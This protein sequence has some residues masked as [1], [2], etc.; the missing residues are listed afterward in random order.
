MDRPNLWSDRPLHPANVALASKSETLIVDGGKVVEKLGSQDPLPVEVVAFGWG[1]T[2]GELSALGCD[3]QLRMSEGGKP[4]LTDSGNY[5]L[6]CRFLRGIHDPP[7]LAARIKG[8]TG[9]VEHGLFLGIVHR[10]VVARPDGIE[11]IEK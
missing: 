6:D 7:A 2:C 5:L 11:I 8:I 10:V 3:P 4:F 9:V 1:R